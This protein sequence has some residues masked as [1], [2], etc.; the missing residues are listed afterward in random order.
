MVLD[1]KTMLGAIAGKMK[2]RVLVRQNAIEVCE[3]TKIINN[4]WDEFSESSQ[5]EKDSEMAP[6]EELP[7]TIK[8][9]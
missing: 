1:S 7:P 6:I 5:S 9:S 8:K 3:E 4:K 2:K